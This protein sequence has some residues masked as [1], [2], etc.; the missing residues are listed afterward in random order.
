MIKILGSMKEWIST[1]EARNS[2]KEKTFEMELLSG[3][4]GILMEE[5]VNN[6]CILRKF[7]CHLEF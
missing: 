3:E 7:E 1:R 6:G 5:T 4:R 2:N